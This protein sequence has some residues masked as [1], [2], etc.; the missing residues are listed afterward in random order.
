MNVAAG[1][2]RRAAAAVEPSL[3]E[4]PSSENADGASQI[5]GFCSEFVVG[6]RLLP[7]NGYSGT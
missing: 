6:P 4:G 3:G 5:L 1:G 2:G 7:V